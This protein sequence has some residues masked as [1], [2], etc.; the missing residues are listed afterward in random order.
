MG[1]GMLIEPLCLLDAVSNPAKGW[2][3]IICLITPFSWLV[4]VARTAA[5]VDALAAISMYS[6]VLVIFRNSAQIP[7]ARY[8]W[9]AL[10][11]DPEIVIR[12]LPHPN[13][14][15]S[16]RQYFVTVVAVFLRVLP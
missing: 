12:L 1:L 15:D 3:I 9:L 4:A 16:V 7:G 6:T 5:V 11:D 8:D 13:A 10:I 14:V 2:L